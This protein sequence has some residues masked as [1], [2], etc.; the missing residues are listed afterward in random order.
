MQQS[1]HY[2]AC[3]IVYVN[4]TTHCPFADDP[5]NPFKTGKVIHG[6]EIGLA[7]LSTN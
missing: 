7:Q 2:N 6:R 5:K 3:L 1:G 4:F